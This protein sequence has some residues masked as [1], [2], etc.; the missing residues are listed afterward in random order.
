MCEEQK[1][2]TAVLNGDV[3]RYE[4][5][6]N[7]YQGQ[8]INYVYRM[9]GNFEDAS[10]IAGDAFIKAFTALKTYNNAY[11]FSTWLYR[12]A[13]NT[14]I[15]FLRKKRL[16]TVSMEG[17]SDED[18]VPQY[19]SEDLT[20]LEE[21]EKER[22]KNLISDAVL[23]LPPEYREVIVLYHINGVPYEEISTITALPL[24]TV[25]NRIFRARQMLKK[26]LEGD[27]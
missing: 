3:D 7:R 2:I 23:K 26:I 6:V 12:I 9:V 10:E 20:P 16:Q 25:K 17:N 11:K 18:Y 21:M 1:V 19:K 27:L 4:F 8:I 13:S 15:D 5:L 22:V 24:G 14:A